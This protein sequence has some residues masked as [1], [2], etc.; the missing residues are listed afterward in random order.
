[1]QPDDIKNLIAFS[2]LIVSAIV[3]I[4]MLYF[5]TK[6]H[7]NLHEQTLTNRFKASME[8]DTNFFKNS[9]NKQYSKNVND[10][11][12]QSLVGSENVDAFLVNLLL[13]FHERNLVDI[14]EMMFLFK[15]GCKYGYLKYEK[16][17][18]INKSLDERVIESFR[19]YFSKKNSK[20]YYINQE[21]ISKSRSLA[22]KLFFITFCILIFYSMF[23]FYMVLNSKS[24][25][26]LIFPLIFGVLTFFLAF[27]FPN[28]KFSMENTSKF[29]EKFYEA[30]E[31]YVEQNNN[32]EL[33]FD[34][35]NQ[36]SVSNY[37]EYRK[38]Y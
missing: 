38:R 5:K 7:K 28:L 35:K 34:A 32:E 22:K 29:L 1:M 2:G 31:N 8:Y 17:T 33:E 21:K 20:I 12:A 30:Y 23:F 16:N 25:Y 15:D 19:F 11:A 13:E 6:E 24:F 9:K 14:N 18:N 4:P 3:G 26:D 36:S 37:S 27:I 10:A